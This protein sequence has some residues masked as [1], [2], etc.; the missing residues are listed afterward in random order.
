MDGADNYVDL[1]AWTPG[2]QWSIEAWVNPSSTP[3]G[4]RTIAGGLSEYRDWAATMH[5]GQ[6]GVAI[7]K[8]DGGA[9]TIRSGA[10]ANASPPLP[11]PW[12]T[13]NKA[14][15]AIGTGPSCRDQ[16]AFPGKTPEPPPKAQAVIWPRLL[17]KRRTPLSS[18]WRDSRRICGLST[19]LEMESVRGWVGFNPKDRRSPPA[20]G[21]GLQANGWAIRTGSVVSPTILAG[22]KTLCISTAKVR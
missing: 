8:P 18:P 7:R 3:S 1:G 6:F 4:R 21:L 17:R 10:P 16:A 12:S 13:S 2:S 19:R 5:D 9:E 22:P 14:I 11:A 15:T 20:D